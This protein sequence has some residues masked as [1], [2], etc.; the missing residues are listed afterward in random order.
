MA[1][2]KNTFEYELIPFQDFP[3]EGEPV[4]FIVEMNDGYGILLSG[5]GI[6][7]LHE[8]DSHYD[9]GG[10]QCRHFDSYREWLLE[11]AG[12]EEDEDGNLVG[13]TYVDGKEVELSIEE[14]LKNLT[15]GANTSDGMMLVPGVMKASKISSGYRN[16]ETLF[17]SFWNGEDDEDEDED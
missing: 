14:H 15:E 3:L 10:I 12:V 6:N 8:S 2:K 4:A 17:E 13:G 1:I 5:P 16:P 9:R 7:K 11:E